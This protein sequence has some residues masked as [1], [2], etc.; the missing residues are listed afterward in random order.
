MARR[1]PMNAPD[2]GLREK[3]LPRQA[4]EVQNKAPA[5]HQITAEQMVREAQEMQFEKQAAP[6]RQ[7]ITDPEELKMYKLRKRKKFENTLR[8]NRMV[9]KSTLRSQSEFTPNNL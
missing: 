6:P 4:R 9:C 2:T 8:R 7:Q 1:G 5:P 3:R